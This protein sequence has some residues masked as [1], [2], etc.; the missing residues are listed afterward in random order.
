MRPDTGIQ[1]VKSGRIPDTNKAGLSG[2]IPDIKKAGLS[3]RIPDIKKAGLSGRISGASLLIIR[4]TV[5]DIIELLTQLSVYFGST[6]IKIHF[7]RYQ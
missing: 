2:R 7:Y 6:G 3:G 5:T 1:Q 4:S